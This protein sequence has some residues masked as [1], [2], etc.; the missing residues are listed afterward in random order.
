MKT[1][2]GAL[3]LLRNYPLSPV[4][5]IVAFVL[6]TLF[7]VPVTMLI[8]A[9]IIVFGPQAGMGYALISAVSSAVA[10]YLIGAGLGRDAIQGLAR[11][12]I[13]HISQK[14][15]K[16]GIFTIVV[17]RIVPVAPF[18]VINLVAGASHI[19]LR[20]FLWGTL[21]G[22]TPGIAA[23][24]LLTDRVQATLQDPQTGTVALLGVI[25]LLVLLSSFLLSR[26][27]LKYS[28]D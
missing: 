7:M 1:I 15:A 11:G 14:L 17:V 12:R 8:V 25:A 5:L 26:Y 2:T 18:T 13:N 19:K 4:L 21:L 6:A 24:A 23:I 10:G 28:E 16:Q 27:L 3:E 22:M 9:S 20:D